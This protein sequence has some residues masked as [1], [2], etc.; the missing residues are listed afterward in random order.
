MIWPAGECQECIW[1]KGQGGVSEGAKEEG[2]IC[3]RWELFFGSFV[4]HPKMMRGPKAVLIFSIQEE[5]VLVPNWSRIKRRKCCLRK[6]RLV[7]SYRGRWDGPL[8]GDLAA[9]GGARHHFLTECKL[10]ADTSASPIHCQVQWPHKL[11]VMWRP[12]PGG[13]RHNHPSVLPSLHGCITI[14]KQIWPKANCIIP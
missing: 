4:V 10:P 13:G 5:S 14:H 12:P 2:W 6:Q 3:G 7:Q 1:W 9:G 11:K 8:S